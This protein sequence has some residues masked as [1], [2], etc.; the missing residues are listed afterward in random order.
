D[1]V[2]RRETVTDETSLI[3][4]RLVSWCDGG[5]TDL[6]LTTG[7]TGLSSRDVTPEATRAAIDREANGIAERIR[8]L[9]LESFPRAALSRG[10]AG[11]RA[12]TLV[13]NLPGSPNGVRDG[14]AAIEPIIDH[15]VDVLAGRV[16]Q[17][18]RAHVTGASSSQ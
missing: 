6:V 7:G 13:I 17:H 8:I 15:A 14:L 1:T 4:G 2:T 16:T 3:T 9:S 11:V 12:S 5:D 18:D 10:I